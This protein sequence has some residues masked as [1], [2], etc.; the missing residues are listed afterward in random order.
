MPASRSMLMYCMS[1]TGDPEWR[2]EAEKLRQ[3]DDLAGIA[4][5]AQSLIARE[6]LTSAIDSAKRTGVFV[7]PE[8]IDDMRTIAAG[9]KLGKSQ[10]AAPA[11][12]A[13]DNMMLMQYGLRI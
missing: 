12:S 11:T 1:E 3:D 5:V 6:D 10:E 13:S 2:V 4:L 8:S 7:V 9:S